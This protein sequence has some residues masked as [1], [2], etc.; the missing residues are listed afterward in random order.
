M[1]TAISLALTAALVALPPTWAAA[2]SVRELRAF[3]GYAYRP[4]RVAD[5]VDSAE[6]IVRARVVSADSAAGESVVSFAP[7]EWM[8]G[9]PPAGPLRVRGTLVERDDYNPRPV[10]YTMVR[11]AGQRGD[12]FAQEYRRGGEYLLLLRGG[13]PYWKALAPLNEQVRGADD[14]WAVWV[15]ARAAS[16]GRDA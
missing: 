13:T 12:C 3:P 14:A 4:A 9:G 1:R 8:R 11:P 10:P 16:R 15:R 7:L 5:F 2:C 6:V